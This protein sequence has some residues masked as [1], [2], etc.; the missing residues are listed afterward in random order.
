MSAVT[1]Q[2]NLNDTAR[3]SRSNLGKAILILFITSLLLS[4]IGISAYVYM[5]LDVDTYY[6][7]V[8]IDGIP[9]EGMTPAQAQEAIWRKHQPVLD[10]MKIQLVYEGKAWE[11]DHESIKA[12]INIDEKVEEAYRV[13]RTGNIIER[14]KE[15]LLV[16]SQ[17]K[18]Y[19]TELTYD[20]S[21]LKED[22]QNIADELYVEPADAEIEFHNKEA[23]MFT[24][25]PEV[26][27][28]RI[29]V[30]DIL[31]AI[32]EKT[33]KR[34]F[35]PYEIKAETIH[36]K[37]TLEEVKTWTDKL[38]TFETPLTNAAQRNHNIAL[39]SSSFDGIRID[40]GQVFSLNEA[41]GPRGFAEGYKSAPVIVNGVKLVDE[42]G[43]GNCQTSTTLYGA[44]IR[45][46]MEVIERWNHSFPI[47]YTEIGQDAMVDYPNFDL[48]FRNPKDS[49]IFIS[50]TIKDNKLIVEIYGKKSEDFDRIEIVTE[51]LSHSA[52]PAYV[53]VADPNLYEGEIVVE[54]KS[55]SEIKTQSYRIYYKDG[56]EVKRVKEAYTH[57]RKVTG[58]RRVGTKPRP[59][60]PTTTVD[61]GTNGSQEQPAG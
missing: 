43:G 1:Q 33:D 49:P 18:T 47:S 60:E 45:A 29:S 7:G 41:T 5:L 48:K 40:P 54:Y 14:I 30:D 10:E 16:K 56:Q 39:S 3:R 8:S 15:I 51:V 61:N 38:V 53:D 52:T 12:A 4:I 13:G 6:P 58:K 35:S 37:Y 57:H 2:H 20:T 32:K 19:R 22:I 55:R 26:I 11:Y 25:T 42:P 59:V 24:F 36:P 27:G 50:R 28:R 17:G 31:A 9:L 34:D 46:D 44:I 23:E 21:V